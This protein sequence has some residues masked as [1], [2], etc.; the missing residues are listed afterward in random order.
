MLASFSKPSLLITDAYN[1]GV[2]R[3]K[4]KE[5]GKMLF[6]RAVRTL[7]YLTLALVVLAPLPLL[8]LL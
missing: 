2:E 8:P 3:P 7:R 4:L 1:A 5:R 6:S